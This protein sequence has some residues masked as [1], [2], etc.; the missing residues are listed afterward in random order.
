MAK[1]KRALGLLETTICGVGVILGA[2]IYALIGVGAGLAGSALWLAFVIAGIVAAFSALSY[3][4]LSSMFP[5]ASGGYEYVKNAFGRRPAFLV[6]WLMLAGII[7]SCVAVS[8]GFANYFCG[9]T[10]TEQWVGAM[11]IVVLCTMILLLG[12]KESALFG[13]LTT[14]IETLGL[15]IIIAIAVPHL[16]SINYLE[17]APIGIAGVF[18]ASALVFFAY[19]GFEDMVKLSEELKSPEKNMP[20]A[21]LIAIAVTTILYVLVS[22]SAVSIMPWQ[23]LSASKAPLADAAGKILGSS[24]YSLVSIIALFA[25]ANTVLFMLLAGSRLIYGMASDD[26]FPKILSFVNKR[27]VPIYAT[28]IVCGLTYAFT[29]IGDIKLAASVTDLILFVVFAA[30]NTCVIVLRYKLPNIKRTFKT[31]VNIGDFPLLAFFGLLTSVAMIVNIEVEAFPYLIALI[32]IGGA[33]Y[34]IWNRKH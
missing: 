19:L 10:G 20:K 4:E 13:I 23:E 29:Y 21:I 12:I 22:I 16:G 34:V 25:T 3:A 26:A 6:G 24:V 17:F 33:V 5:K 18:A 27:G 2:G 14:A 11:V 1:L 32:L 8:L 7:V 15:L 31:P 30:V 28:I 9:L